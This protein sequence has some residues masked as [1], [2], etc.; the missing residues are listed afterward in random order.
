MGRNRP[1]RDSLSQMHEGFMQLYS[2]EFEK[3]L[4]SQIQLQ[5]QKEC[6]LT[7]MKAVSAHH[8]FG[9]SVICR[10][11]DNASTGQ[12][13]YRFMSYILPITPL[14]NQ[15]QTQTDWA[16]PFLAGVEAFYLTFSERR[17]GPFDCKDSDQG[18]LIK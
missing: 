6:A 3:S 14:A 15:C 11:N 13:H 5:D 7:A 17:Y 2:G 1:T 16:N 12:N 9:A 18:A 4:V 8:R 10:W